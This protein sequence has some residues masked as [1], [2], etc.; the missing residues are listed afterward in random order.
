MHRPFFVFRIMLPNTIAN[1]DSS[2]ILNPLDPALCY[3]PPETLMTARYVEV[4]T[5]AVFVWELLNNLL[6]DYKLLSKY[7]IR[8]PIVVYFISRICSLGFAISTVVFQTAPVNSCYGLAKGL[9]VFFLLSV[10]STSLLFFLRIQ[11]VFNGNQWIVNLFAGLWL[12]VAASCSTVIIGVDGFNIGSTNY[13]ID[14]QIKPFVMTGTI[15]PLINDI[16]VFLAIAWRLFRNSYAPHTVK[17]GVRFLVFGDYLPRF[18]K[19][20]LQDG[21]AYYLAS[22]AVSF[23]AVITLFNRSI[24]DILRTVFAVP[25]VIL[26]NIMACR[27]FRNT[28]LE[29]YREGQVSINLISRDLGTEVVPLPIAWRGE[30]DCRTRQAGDAALDIDDNAITQKVEPQAP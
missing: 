2:P 11:A 9:G 13:C 29:I 4:G 20:I 15:V 22:I 27:A 25:N 26:M 21:Q 3:L 10:T 5:L 30:T 14:G 12:A 1:L 16:L 6:N 8:L 18:F 24:P 19:A 7:R 28:I 23:I 17:N